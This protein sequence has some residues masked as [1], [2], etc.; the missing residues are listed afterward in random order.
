MKQ[1]EG[2]HCRGTPTPFTETKTKTCKPAHTETSVITI[3]EV[4]K[5]KIQE[6]D[7]TITYDTAV[8]GTQILHE[9]IF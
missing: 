1:R 9:I 7:P 5:G 4:S 3:L 6:Q 2:E 8:Q